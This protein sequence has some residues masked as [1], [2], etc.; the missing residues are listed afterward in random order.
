MAAQI[1]QNKIALEAKEAEVSRR[2]MDV[3]AAEKSLS[4]DKQEFD[5]AVRTMEPQM[6]ALRYEAEQV[7]ASKQN[8][9]A[10]WEKVRNQ[11][12]NA[13]IA[14]NE[15]LSKERDMF[16]L[17]DQIARKREELTSLKAKLQSK[18]AEIQSRS[19][20][21][22]T[23]KF[24]IYEC[25]MTLS[26]EIQNAREH[27]MGFTK[28]TAAASQGSSS[29]GF[30]IQDSIRNIDR[31]G[32]KVGNVIKCLADSSDTS[33]DG[34]D[35]H[36]WDPRYVASFLDMKDIPQIE[37]SRTDEMKREILGSESSNFMVT[38]TPEGSWP[39]LLRG[40][41]VQGGDYRGY[42]APKGVSNVGIDSADVKLTID[43][44][45]QSFIGLKEFGLKYGV[46]A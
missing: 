25:A 34:S 18:F 4:K 15:I 10:Y 33:L 21:I 3:K 13:L 26:S 44:A 14:E 38:G 32:V 45:S 5:L 8:A 20:A 7:A 23:S 17:A 6:K 22:H 39:S 2:E 27:L 40:I 42:N 43:A 16:A 19:K 46:T 11:A 24:S 9:E 37:V 30:M 28:R 36:D 29:E 31:C 12:D 35:S 41:H 1:S